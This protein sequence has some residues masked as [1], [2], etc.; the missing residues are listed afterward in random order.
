MSAKHGSGLLKMNA[1]LLVA[2]L[3]DALGLSKAGACQHND[4]GLFKK[5]LW[6]VS[7]DDF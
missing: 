5:S 4:L 7:E 3:V 2:E 1:D 6:C